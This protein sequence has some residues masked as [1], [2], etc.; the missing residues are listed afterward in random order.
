MLIDGIEQKI[1]ISIFCQKVEEY[2]KYI[3]FKLELS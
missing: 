3:Y 2:K 1:V